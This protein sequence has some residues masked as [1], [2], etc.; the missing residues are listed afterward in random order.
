MEI[1]M[2][3]FYTS[4]ALAFFTFVPQSAKAVGLYESLIQPAL[5]NCQ[6]DGTHLRNLTIKSEGYQVWEIG[7]HIYVKE[8][9]SVL[10]LNAFKKIDEDVTSE[11]QKDGDDDKSPSTDNE[12]N[13]ECDCANGSIIK[14]DTRTLEERLPVAGTPYWLRY[15]SGKVLGRKMERSIK[16][17]LNDPHADVL[18][19]TLSGT[20]A[21]GRTFGGDYLNTPGQVFNFLWDGLDSHGASLPST[22][23]VF[24]ITYHL[25][26]GLKDV[27][28]RYEKFLTGSNS[29][30]KSVGGW[31]PENLHYYDFLKGMIMFGDGNVFKTTL[32]A[33]EGNF[34][35]FSDDGSEAY[36]FDSTG[37][38]L[39][40]I[41]GL[42]GTTKYEFIYDSTWGK[43]SKIKNASGEETI[44]SI[45]SS[46]GR[47]T[48]ITSP[49]GLLTVINYDSNGYAS[50]MIN[51]QGET[52][53]M[54]YS[55]D[56]LILTFVKP[57]GETSTLTYD[58]KGGLEKDEHS[59]GS[60]LALSP[61]TDNSGYP[62]KFIDQITAMGRTSSRDVKNAYQS[63]SQ[64]NAGTRNQKNGNASVRYELGSRLETFDLYSQ[65]KSYKVDSRNSSSRYTARESMKIGSAVSSKEYLR[66]V[67][68]GVDGPFKPSQMTYISK[69]DGN[70]STS[71]Y[72]GSTKTWESTSAEGRKST[73][74]LDLLERPVSSRVGNL[75]QT[76]YSYY[77]N[78]NISK[79]V[80][81]DRVTSLNYENRGYVS[82]IVNPLG[83]ITKFFRDN[84]GR[85]LS[86]IEPGNRETK[87]LYDQN[88]RMTSLT[89][90]NGKT[91][92]FIYNEQEL[93]SEYRPPALGSEVVKTTYEYNLDKDLT[94][95]TLPDGRE[96]TY[97]YQDSG[98]V[99]GFG[100]SSEGMKYYGWGNSGTTNP[101]EIK[102]SGTVMLSRAY[103]GPYLKSET[104]SLDDESLSVVSKVEFGFDKQFRTSKVTVKDT[105]GAIGHVPRYFYDRDNLLIRAGEVV[106]VRDSLGKVSEKRIDNAQILQ[107]YDSNY[108]EL[109]KIEYR[110]KGKTNLINTF[111]RDKLGRI[112][113]LA[114]GANRFALFYDRSGRFT[115]RGYVGAGTPVSQFIYDK[116][117]NRVSGIDK[118]VKFSAQY[119]DHDRLVKYN[120]TTFTYGLNGELASKTTGSETTNYTFDVY[121]NLYNVQQPDKTISY[122]FDALD[123][124]VAKFV[125]DNLIS[126]YVWQDQLRL[127]AELNADGS[128]KKQFV[129]ADGVNSPE[130]MI[131]EGKRYFF[132]KDHRGSINLVV[133]VD[134][135]EVVQRMS[136][137]EFGEVI[138][139]TNPGFQPFGFAGGL[140][141]VD[142]KL[143]KFGARDY[144][145]S[146]GR[147]LSKDPILFA[148]GDTNLYGYVMQDPINFIDTDGLSKDPVNR[149]QAREGENGGGGGGSGGGGRSGGGGQCFSPKIQSQMTQRGWTSDTIQEA[150][151]T[152]GIPTIGKLGPATRYVHPGTGQSI[153][154][155][156]KT[157]EVF[158]V[159]GPGFK[160]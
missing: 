38:H 62:I 110:F 17:P 42:M 98:R 69:S 58:V 154:V 128:M 10:A 89:T 6:D 37:K 106:I 66:T 114:D 63:I 86:K 113:E 123:R 115:G 64:G 147:W 141:D 149:M 91:H 84:M 70:E 32:T 5:L 4:L 16:I 117:G 109:N 138:E 155:D 81:G 19:F 82:Q 111:K 20:Y 54:T 143:V 22:T 151:Q 40:T 105:A 76:K 36:V 27:P 119:D 125:S 150:R 78:D 60:F 11:E 80:Q 50:Q 65:S 127:T 145:P 47:I 93:L 132:V 28:I 21:D 24:Y 13:P 153:V 118:G 25:D 90:P 146:I 15:S 85:V 159:G 8:C 96:I 130:Y 9:H 73:Q 112:S 95:I 71:V 152:Q 160:Y 67:V 33:F 87:Y 61:R 126:R 97:D 122:Q 79:I 2:N 94:K 131:F 43:I 139:D 1:D 107:T 53:S 51:P 137:S 26:N 3:K 121:G 83:E 108:G 124:R 148:G 134:S 88:G 14:I 100:S 44:F 140:Y 56:G 77:S 129:Y 133:N 103:F 120:D 30:Y 136:Y 142:T 45:N 55:S 39:R 157:G 92:E 104:Q 156:D 29:S 57:E 12:E 59:G 35:A 135:G 99:N 68:P 7:R 75:L 72:S 101:E 116:N 31:T 102:R 23:I 34:R 52:Y 46:N 48:S 49:K 18:G 158:H 41:N 144:D 74:T